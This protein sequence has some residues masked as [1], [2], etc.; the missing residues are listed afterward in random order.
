MNGHQESDREPTPAPPCAGGTGRSTSAGPTESGLLRA[1]AGANRAAP[2]GHPS[3]VGGDPR[4]GLP[5]SVWLA[6]ALLLL[7][8]G[9]APA[10]VARL[11]PVQLPADARAL[12]PVEPPPA[13]AL[14][15][16]HP[17]PRGGAPAI[18]AASRGQ[19]DPGAGPQGAPLPERSPEQ[20]AARQAVLDGFLAQ[21]L[22]VDLDQAWVCLEAR[23]LAR[24]QPLEYVLVGPR[25]QGHESLFGT[26]VQPSALNAALLMLGTAAG[27]N[28]RWIELPPDADAAQAS[29]NDGQ[30]GPGGGGAPTPAQAPSEAPAP[31]EEPLQDVGAA[32]DEVPRRPRFR[33]ELPSGDGLFLYAAWRSEGEAYF[34]RVE[35][36][37]AN[38][39]QERAM[40]RHRFVYLGSR[41]VEPKPGAQPAFAADLEQNLINL[42][43]F[44]AGNTLLTAA[45]RESED[46]E[47]WFANPWLLPDS[48]QPVLFLLSRQALATLPAALEERLPESLFPSGDS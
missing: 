29:P 27:Q 38:V 8:G 43:F 3:P 44:S 36:L 11:R 5:L 30:G 42:V 15:A 22:R 23:V 34:F 24:Y 48:D 7:A 25:G 12:P 9:L 31:S 46:E 26:Q 41:W 10:A 32:A 47:A 6:L 33:I 37:L 18:G 16:A 19:S 14:P 45:V 20:A 13:A 17:G 2:G 1:R 4:A 28:A 40:R 39:R 21:G 35:D